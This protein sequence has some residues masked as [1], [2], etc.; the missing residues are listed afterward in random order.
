M[1]F[2]F[3]NP[4]GEIL[5]GKLELPTGKT[6]ALALFAHCFTCSKN[7]HAAQ[8]ISKTLTAHGIAV[9]RFDFTGIGNSQ[10]DFAN[11]NFSSNVEDLIAASKHLGEQLMLPELLIGHSFGGAA[12]LKAAQSLPHVKGLVTINS[13]SD[14]M[15]IKHLF[16]E[17]L[18]DIKAGQGAE[19]KLGAKTF[20]I[21]KQFLDDLTQADILSDFKRLKKALL[22]MHSPLDEM[23]SI[24]HASEIFSAV[25]HPKSFI[26]L[27]KADH[28]LSKKADAQYAGHVIGA[29]SKHYISSNRETEHDRE[30]GSVLVKSR[31]GM[32][33]TQDIYS[34]NHH[35]IADEPIDKKGDDLGPDPYALLLSSLGACTSMTIK[36]YAKHKDI[37]LEGVEVKLKHQRVYTEDCETCE[38][39][40]AHIEVI[41]KEINLFGDLSEAQKTR[42][43]EIADKCPVNK[44][45]QSQLKIINKNRAPS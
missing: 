2:D 16:T 17:K 36:M 23:V 42:I 11:T 8:M 28:L 35:L 15:H 20:S 10:G 29:W 40:E 7:N 30:Q 14:A 43:Y 39:K 33:L 4:Q 27:D 6:Q 13:P 34:G 38:K 44:T 19:V 37:P 22:V 21:N 18:E 41:E 32:P 25:N 24:D 5:S 9:L 26:S 3:P 12:V 31:S 1:R 45:L